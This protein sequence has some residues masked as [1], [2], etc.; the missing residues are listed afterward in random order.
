W[1]I[2][3]ARAAGGKPL[4]AGDPHIAFSVPAVWYEA[5]LSSPNFELY[6]LHQALN[7]FALIGHNQR[8]GWSLTMFQNDDL[9]FVAEKVNPDNPRQ[10]WVKDAWADLQERQETIKVKG[11]PAV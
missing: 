7:P 5:H 8:F 10:V 3:G 4:L 6:G 11:A 1:V 2:S 9:D